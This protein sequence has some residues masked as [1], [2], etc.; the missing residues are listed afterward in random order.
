MAK[1]KKSETTETP[2]PTGKPAV[3]AKK[4]SGG[5]KAAGKKSSASAGGGGGTPAA[6]P[7]IDTGLAASAAAAMILNRAVTG[8]A[9]PPAP[10]AGAGQPAA[11][12][13]SASFKHLKESL[14]KP[15]AG[16]L[17]GVLGTSQLH[18]K[19][20]LPHGGGKQVGRNQTFGADVSK[21]FV[22]RRTGGG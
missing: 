10:A 20:N 2:T 1:A 5:T 7:R 12:K 3:A 14:S 22:P 15:A 21:N 13:E 6:G 11:K 4:A 9:T 18:K 19:T 17:G 8:G 16:G